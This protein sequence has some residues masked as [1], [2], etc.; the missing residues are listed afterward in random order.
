MLLTRFRFVNTNGLK[1]LN[2][3]G[4]FIPFDK[5]DDKLAEELITKTH[6]L[7]RLPSTEPAPQLA[8]EAPA[9]EQVIGHPEAA[10]PVKKKDE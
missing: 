2:Y 4:D 9:A 10:T 7:E 5:I 6:V 1:G 3:K 8:L